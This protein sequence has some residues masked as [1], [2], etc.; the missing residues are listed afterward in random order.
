MLSIF[1]Y[2]AFLKFVGD[3]MFHITGLD[4][5]I[6]HIDKGSLLAFLVYLELYIR[7]SY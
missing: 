3:R 5:F 1:H 6:I 2:Y 7:G 4:A